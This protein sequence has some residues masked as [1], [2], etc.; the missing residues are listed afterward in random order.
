MAWLMN[1]ST[2]CEYAIL[3]V[4]DLAIVDSSQPVR[5]ADIASRQNIPQKFL[6]GILAELKRAGILESRRGAEGGYLLARAADLINVGEVVRAIEGGRGKLAS[7]D[8]GP[9]APLFRDLDEV[10]AGILD[11]RSFAELAR[12]W[13]EEKSGVTPD[14][15]I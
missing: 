6:E 5:I 12:Q 2:K 10:I 3:A 9:L 13:R 8:N 11:R 14:W 4:L 7:G 1:L 15:Q